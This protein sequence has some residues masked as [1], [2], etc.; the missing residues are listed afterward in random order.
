MHVLQK[1]A[2]G[3]EVLPS[4]SSLIHVTPR[5]HPEQRFLDVEALHALLE[6]ADPE[7]I[8]LEQEKVLV[9]AR[10]FDVA[11]LVHDAGMVEGVPLFGKG[12]DFSLMLRHDASGVDVLFGAGEFLDDAADEA[13]FGMAGKDLPLA[14]AAVAAADVIGVH[15]RDE[16]V[17]A[18]LHAEVQSTAE[19]LIFKQ[20]TN[21]QPFAEFFLHLADDGVKFFCQRTVADEDKIVRRHGLA[22]DAL[23]AFAQV[24]GLFLVVDGHQHRIRAHTSLPCFSAFFSAVYSSRFKSIFSKSTAPSVALLVTRIL[25]VW[26][27]MMRSSTML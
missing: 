17:F 6:H 16:F 27:M 1:S 9:A 8:V 20:P 15:A 12:E 10:C 7:V 11:F 13:V 18:H 5:P 3:Q 23:H 24:C 22:V 26:I 25:M 19:A 2:L 21:V 4:P 14:L